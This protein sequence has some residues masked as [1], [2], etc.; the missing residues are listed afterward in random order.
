M[1]QMQ[2]NHTRRYI[3]MALVVVAVVVLDQ[4]TKYIVQANMYLHQSIPVM[5]DFFRLTYIENPGMAFGIQWENKFLFSLFSVSA[6]LIVL[7][8]IYRMRDEHWSVRLALASILGGAIGNLIDR[9]S[10][11]RVVDFLD[12]EFFDVSI[13]SFH[14]LFFDFPGYQM[15]RWPVF[16]VADIAVSVGMVIISGLILFYGNEAPAQKTVS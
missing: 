4:I 14:F 15:Y 12:F 9:F 8:Y 10:T 11:G 1:E 2:E 13:P 16:N 5:G 7:V 6:A 3:W